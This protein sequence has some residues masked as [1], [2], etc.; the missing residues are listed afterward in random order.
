MPISPQ[1]LA[2][3]GF[4]ALALVAAGCSSSGGSSSG[5]KAGGSGQTISVQ[6][7]SGAKVLVDGSGRSLYF[8]D[9]E[10][11]AHRVLCASS[12]CEAIWTPVTVTA[13]QQPTSPA[14]VTSGLTTVPRPG[15][16][17]QVAYDGAPL[18]TFSFDHS[19]GQLNGDNQRDSFDGTDFTWQAATFSGAIAPPPSSP[20]YGG[21]YGGGY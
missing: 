19:A 9:Q 14:D 2:V 12:A 18:Y 15:G 10:K 21:S 13:G 7:V 8:S 3:A 11:A 5:S 1:L 4:S 16:G 6:T 17:R 20:S